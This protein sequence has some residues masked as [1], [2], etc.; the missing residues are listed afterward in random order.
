MITCSTRAA[1]GEREDA[2]G[3]AV[4]AALRDAGFDVA[5]E[6]IVLPDDEDL[7]AATLAA[8][9]DGGRAAHRDERRDGAD[10]RR[11]HARPPRAA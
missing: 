9:A 6:P 4:V 8:L 11:S 7:I 3:P 2:S 10:A 5:P 1:A